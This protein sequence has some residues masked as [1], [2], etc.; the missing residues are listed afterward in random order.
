MDVLCCAVEGRV[1]SG[2]GRSGRP[3][4]SGSVQEPKCALDVWLRGE[5]YSAKRLGRP[6]Q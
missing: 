3:T 5:K 2:R 4:G 6:L 1:G